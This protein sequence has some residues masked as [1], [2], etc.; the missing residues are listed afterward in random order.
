MFGSTRAK[1]K[2]VISHGFCMLRFCIGLIARQISEPGDDEALHKP[3]HPPLWDTHDACFS[4][5]F[6]FITGFHDECFG[7]LSRCQFHRPANQ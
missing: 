7:L 1:K 3:P 2:P 6:V 5:P 4:L